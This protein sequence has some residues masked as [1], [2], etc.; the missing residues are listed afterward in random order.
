ME[1]RRVIWSEGLGHCGACHTPKNLLGAATRQV[2]GCRVMRCKAGSRRISPTIRAAG[3]GRW[4]VDEIATYLKTGHNR[5]SA[6]NGPMSENVNLST[7]QITDADLK[8]I[9]TYLKDRPGDPAKGDENRNAVHAAAG[10]GGDEGRGA[11]SMRTNVR[12]ATRLM[13]RAR[14]ACSRRSP[15]A[16]TVQQSRSDFALARRIARRAQRRDRRRR[17]GGDAGVRWLLTDDQVAAVLTYIRNSWGN[18]ASSVSAAEVT[19]AR[20]T[21][22]ERSD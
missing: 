22:V 20:H 7:S 19:E 21:F 2:S 6:A 1:S 18:A 17:R 9:A 10:S 12:A 13:A 8:A 4:S 5:T 3:I 15:A 11:G 14:R 16:P